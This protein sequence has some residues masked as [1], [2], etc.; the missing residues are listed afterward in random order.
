MIPMVAVIAMAAVAA[1]GIVMLAVPRPQPDADVGPRHRA[2]ER[3]SD[4]DV[5]AFAGRAVHALRR[6]RGSLLLGGLRVARARGSGDALRRV[7][8]SLRREG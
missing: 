7:S 5:G 8:E 1:R 3:V 6:S 2:E 4:G